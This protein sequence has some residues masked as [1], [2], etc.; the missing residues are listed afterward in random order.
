MKIFKEQSVVAYPKAG[1]IYIG[2][3]IED[4]K[5]NLGVSADWDAESIYAGIK[6]NK[7]YSKHK[8]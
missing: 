4:K 3:E 8:K 6:C 2:F 1:L 5:Q 7:K